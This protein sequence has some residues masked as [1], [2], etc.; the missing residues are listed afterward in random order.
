MALSDGEEEGG[1]GGD[2]SGGGAQPHTLQRG[3]SHSDS[4][5]A[6][7]HASYARRGGAA[8]SPGRRG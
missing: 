1:D 5:A 2:G 4:E 7:H 6:E 8:R 3:E